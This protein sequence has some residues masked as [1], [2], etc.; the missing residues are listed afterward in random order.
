[1]EKNQKKAKKEQKREKE[2]K[3]GE[4]A[5]FLPG[6][7]RKQKADRLKRYVITLNLIT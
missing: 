6:R 3:T 1:M 7:L 2:E 4:K 5:F